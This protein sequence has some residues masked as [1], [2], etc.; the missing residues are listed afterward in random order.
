[1]KDIKETKKRKKLTI[2]FEVFEILNNLKEDTR[3]KV[4]NKLLKY[5]F[6]GTPPNL[7]SEPEAIQN[8]F[9]CLKYELNKIEKQFNNGCKNKTRSSPVFLSSTQSVCQTMPTNAKLS[10][11]MPVSDYMY[12]NI[13]NNIIY[14]TNKHNNTNIKQETIKKD[15]CLFEL[16]EENKINSKWWQERLRTEIKRI[17]LK[18]PRNAGRF[19]ELI[20]RVSQEQSPV[21]I[22]GYY[23]APELILE[24][25]LNIFRCETNEAV[26]RIEKLYINIDNKIEKN[27]PKITNIY[28]YM[29]AYFYNVACE[30]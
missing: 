16:S 26:E 2:S 27:D 1:M 18:T 11:T 15:V 7:E 9:I 5:F 28:K 17:E 12:N 10:Q 6:M 3:N 8:A 24:K 29:V 4:W 13:Y 23:M 30:Y 21:K 20:Q 19:G 14:N 22:Q 25:Y